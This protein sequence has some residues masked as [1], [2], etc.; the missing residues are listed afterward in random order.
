[1]ANLVSTAFICGYKGYDTCVLRI[2]R[3][4]CSEE[5]CVPGG[6]AGPEG[7]EYSFGNE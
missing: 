2:D 6:S 7:E 3:G 5:S 1:M 4:S